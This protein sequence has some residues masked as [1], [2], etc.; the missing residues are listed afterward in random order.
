MA[1]GTQQKI[2]IEDA[3]AEI[4]IDKFY[5]GTIIDG[6]EVGGMTPDE[7]YAAVSASLPEEPEEVAVKLNV[8]GKLYP[9]DFTDVTFEYNAR[10]VVDEAYS[11]YRPV[12]EDP[13]QLTEYYNAI[14][15]LKVTPLEYETAYSV[16]IDGIAEKVHEVLDPLLD[17]YATTKD[18]AIE[19]FDPET[20][21]FTITKEQKGYVLDVDGAIQGVK[22]LFD[23]K[24]YSGMVKVPTVL[25]APDVTEEMLNEQFGLVSEFST[26]C[27]SNTNRNNNIS[28]ACKYISGTIL[29]P[30]EQFSFNKVVG[31][32]TYDRGFRE[33]TVILGGQ[34]EQG[35][36]GGICQVSST[37]YNAVA[38]ADLKVVE[39]NNHAWPSDYVL[40]G[41]DATVDYPAL[42]FKFENNTDFQVIVVM[43][44]KDNTV[45]AEIYGKKLPDGQYIK[46]E[47]NIISTSSA[48]PNE[49]VEDKEM[50]VGQQKT[51]R[52]AHQGQTA[53]IY[54]VW[55]DKDDKEIKRE[56]YYTTSY[57]SFGTRIAV[58]T[59]NPDGT[60]AVLD[61]KT[62]EVSAATITPTPTA[63]P[64]AGPTDAP[65]PTSAP[66]TPTPATPT[67]PPPPTTPPEP[68]T[69]PPPEDQTTT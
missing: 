15:Q 16:H 27:S 9:V 1:D 66:D 51:I 25:K 46:L 37:L 2:K 32:R 29:Q 10:E 48:G 26:K 3:Y 61:T 50:P 23:S 12:T 67:D 8:E 60:Y 28:Q 17:Q 18:A 41:C 53:R 65:P 57:K 40:T 59:K 45:Y 21:T 4:N 55:F 34:Y 54:K 11:K 38:K 49:Y 30:G 5:Q 47:S 43:W 44:F 69:P 14:Q 63:G 42:D 6:I 39:R 20:K 62:G 22:D 13:A 35:L 36:G 19:D 56:E 7:A 58:G 68:T 31:V 52:A 24:K 64:T 33:A